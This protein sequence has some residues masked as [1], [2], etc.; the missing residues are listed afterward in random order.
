MK[1]GDM[2]TIKD[3]HKIPELVGKQAKVIVMVDP[4]Y[5]HYPIQVMLIQPIIIETKMGDAETPGPFAF[6]E[7]EL[8]SYNPNSGIPDA[9][10]KSEN[11]AEGA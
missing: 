5:A 2:V 11:E 9:F 8:E 10:L 1:I 7:D 4:E 3:C 6:R